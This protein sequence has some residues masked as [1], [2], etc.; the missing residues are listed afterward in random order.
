MIPHPTAV[1]YGCPTVGYYNG[2]ECCPSD[3]CR[4]CNLETGTCLECQPGYKGPQCE[5]NCDK[6]KDYYKK[7][8]IC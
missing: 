4:R 8:D 3:E 2:P 1:V 6:G 7:N 5:Q